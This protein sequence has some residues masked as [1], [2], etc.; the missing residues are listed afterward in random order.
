MQA[1]P[2]GLA[3]AFLIG[4]HFLGNSPAALILGDNIFYGTGLSGLLQNAC[5]REDG[6]RSIF[7][8]YVR[9]PERYGIVTFDQH[10]NAVDLKE[11]PRHPRSHYAVT[12]LYFY[13]SDVVPAREI[14]PSARGVLRGL[15]YQ[16]RNPQGKLVRVSRGSVFDVAV[17]VRLGSPS[18][19]HWV[20]VT[21]DD[22]R[23][24][25]LWIPPG[26]A[27]GFCVIS[28]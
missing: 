12:G 25:M 23:H 14:R 3:Q 26:F 5:S 7:G 19:G 20:G 21:L 17:D 13:D 15:H 18:F 1:R 2:E 22:V 28:E 8:Y 16:R 27:H 10:G 6:A 9:D 11:K 4:E 24:E